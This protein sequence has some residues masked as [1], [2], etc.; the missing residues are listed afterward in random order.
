MSTEKHYGDVGGLLSGMN[1]QHESFATRELGG[2]PDH[3]HQEEDPDAD[4]PL[5]A[6]DE[7]RVW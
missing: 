1:A 6:T 7:F 4:S 2:P 5:F 3:F